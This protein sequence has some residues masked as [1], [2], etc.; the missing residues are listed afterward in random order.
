MLSRR[1]GIFVLL[2]LLTA[3][4]DAAVN[5]LVRD[6]HAQP[7]ADAIVTLSPIG[8]RPVAQVPGKASVAQINK[9]F[10]PRVSV[11][12]TGSQVWFPNRDSIRH[13]VYSF[14]AAK[15]FDIKLYAGDPPAP[16]LFDKPG[17]VVLGCNIHDWMIAYVYVTDAPYFG[18][19]DALG[20]L[21]LGSVPAGEYEAHLWHPDQSGPEQV[22]KLRVA[23]D[24]VSIPLT[25]DI[26]AGGK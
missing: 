19:S 26:K 18:K 12:A 8:G 2:T 11:V 6:N 21:D 1:L 9:E 15:R 20:R 14:S 3:H 22:Q 5:M 13:H 24:S 16:V 23:G 7:L 25:V 10:S 4:A 17:L